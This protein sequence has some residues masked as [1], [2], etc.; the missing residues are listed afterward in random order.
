MTGTLKFFCHSV[1]SLAQ[2]H[3]DREWVAGDGALERL[4]ELLAEA[5]SVFKAMPPATVE[6]V[7]TLDIAKELADKRK[8]QC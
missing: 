2:L 1:D 5:E 3:G 7:T 6:S 4:R 8:H